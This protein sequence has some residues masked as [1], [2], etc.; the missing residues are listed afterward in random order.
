MASARPSSTRFWMPYGSRATGNL[1][2]SLISRKSMMSSTF[3]R[4]AISSR[5][6]TPNHFMPCEPVAVH[7][8]VAAGQDVVDDGHLTEQGDVLERPSDAQVGHCIR[9]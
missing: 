2:H 1:R 8:N 6:P 4:L 5:L 9:T 7:P 3:A